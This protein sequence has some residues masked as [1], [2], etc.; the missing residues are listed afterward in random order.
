M[1]SMKNKSLTVIRDS[2][3]FLFPSDNVKTANYQQIRN[4][5]AF[6][7]GGENIIG[8]GRDGDLKDR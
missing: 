1:A 3:I 6:L 7:A 4:K 8:D 5:F 2:P